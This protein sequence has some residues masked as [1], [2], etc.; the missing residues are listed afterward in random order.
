VKQKQK[1]K[2]TVTATME[3]ALLQEVTIIGRSA[4]VMR[5]AGAIQEKENSEIRRAIGRE[6]AAA[7]APSGG[8]SF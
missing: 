5:V 7:L 4:W 1:L 8:R 3:L 6:M 2:V